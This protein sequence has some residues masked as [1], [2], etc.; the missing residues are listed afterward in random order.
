MKRLILF[1][2]VLSLGNL[3]SQKASFKEIGKSAGVNIN[4]K[5]YGAAFAD[6]NNDGYDDLYVSRQGESNRLYKNKDS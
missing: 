6:Y 4:G 2:F 3:Y 5:C 1:F